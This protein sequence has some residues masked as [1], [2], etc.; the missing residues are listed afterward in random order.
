MV[1][2]EGRFFSRLDSLKSKDE[3][4]TDSDRLQSSGT[5]VE[6]VGLSDDLLNLAWQQRMLKV[7]YVFSKPEVIEKVECP[8]DDETLHSQCELFGI[9]IHLH[10]ETKGFKTLK[11]LSF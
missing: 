3:E 2:E 4:L 6:E 7:F 9:T 8:V 1:K 11:D 5:I 10:F